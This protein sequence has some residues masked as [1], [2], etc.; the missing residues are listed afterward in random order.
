MKQCQKQKRNL[1]S[2][3]KCVLSA[4][5]LV[6]SLCQQSFHT[7]LAFFFPLLASEAAASEEEDDDDAVLLALGLGSA[8]GLAFPLR[9]G[10]ILNWI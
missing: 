9:G 4:L 2:T 1:F 8:L 3:P 6:S 7:D 5:D 10:A